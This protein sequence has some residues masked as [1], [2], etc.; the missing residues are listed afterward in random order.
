MTLLAAGGILL[1]KLLTD[2]VQKYKDMSGEMKISLL[3]SKKLLEVQY[4]T[5][6][7]QKNQFATM[8][9]IQ[10]VQTE[11]IGSRGKVFSAM[12]DST[13]ELAINLSD[14]GKAFGYGATEA[15]KIHKVFRNIGADDALAT[16]LQG[17]LGLMSEM[18]GLSPQIIGEDL[19]E[20]SDIVATYFAGMPE[21]AARAALETRRLGM[22][23]KD[24]GAIAQKMLNMDSFMTDMYELQAMTGG[25][26]D[27]SGAFEKGLMGD[28]E[29][30][31]RDIM[32][33]IG[34]S[35]ELNRMDYL[36]RTK[37]AKTLDMSV[38]DLS[39]SV[40]MREQLADYGEVE[41]TYIKGNLQRMGDISKMSQDEIRN[42]LEQL[43]S[44]DRLAVAWDKIKGVLLKSLIP[45][46]ESFSGAIDAIMPIIDGIIFSFKIVG[47]LLKPIAILVKGMLAPFAFVAEKVG[48]LTGGLDESA[49][50]GGML[51]KVAESLSGIFDVV[52]K[53][54]YWIGAGIGTWFAI[55]KFPTL[56]GTI[57][58][59]LANIIKFVPFIGGAFS[60]L[61]GN[62]GGIFGGLGKKSADSAKTMVTP[63][64]GMAATVQTSISAMVEAVK[65]SIDDMASHIKSSMGT[66]QQTLNK[67]TSVGEIIGSAEKA[68]KANI[69]IAKSVEAS[70][71][72]MSKKVK[73][74]VKSASDAA[75]E[76]TEKIKKKKKDKLVDESAGASA[77]KV[78][79]E[80]G[81]KT[82]S[83]MAVRSAMTF[84]TARKEGEEQMGAMAESINPM[85]EM[86]LSGLAPMMMGYLTEGIEKTFTKRLEKRIEGNLEEGPKK[87]KGKIMEIGEAG[88]SV[89]GS[90]K[91]VAGKVFSGLGNI[92]SLF[93]PV[94]TANQ[95]FDAMAGK[96]KKN[97]KHRHSKR[98]YKNR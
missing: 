62:V 33:N 96:I 41:R 50:A 37:I 25:G 54:V 7:S 6:T 8:Q 89:F 3:Q 26:I 20:S 78:L 36:T 93:T 14:M 32:D 98:S 40:R 44:T 68:G 85:I 80:I 49:A 92:G 88:K 4:D 48:L 29:G 73:N 53:A 58:S 39:K 1:G 60:S 45:L 10:D 63:M 64:E 12:R 16:T 77:F 35:A 5:L 43:Q 47:M 86:A 31:T 66:V 15:T 56:I 23:L 72:E 57:V 17:N 71:A 97:Q 59:S 81:A 13:K 24:A 65:K 51:Y 30:M 28:I 9:D 19:V 90:L 74:D 27:F 82:F 52:G 70:S 84:F 69:D 46:A 83:I 87:A 79:G 11:L 34:T 75:D 2:V 76:A 55:T 38:E 61:L 18:V 91:N 22:S 21:K 42:R 67:G 95:S 94:D